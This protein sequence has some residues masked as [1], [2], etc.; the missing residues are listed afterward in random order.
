MKV[1]R[2]WSSY[3]M[4]KSLFRKACFSDVAYITHEPAIGDRL[5]SECNHSYQRDAFYAYSLAPPD[6]G[7]VP[8]LANPSQLSIL[9]YGHC[10]YPSSSTQ[11][12]CIHDMYTSTK[13]HS[14]LS[15][16]PQGA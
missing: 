16:T 10:M 15:I 13:V 7:K 12:Y 5:T 14:T 9:R 11:Q 2:R 3:A 4:R 6:K 1:D 8:D